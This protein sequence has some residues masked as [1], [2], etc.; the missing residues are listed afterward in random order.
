MSVIYVA[1]FSRLA[2]DN[3]KKLDLR[4]MKFLENSRQF[5]PYSENAM[6]NTYSV[7]RKLS[8]EEIDHLGTQ[9]N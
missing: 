4:Q 1:Q 5:S 3:T 7:S 9:E 8:T 6:H 2:E